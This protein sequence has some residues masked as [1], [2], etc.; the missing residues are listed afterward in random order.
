M[1]AFGLMSLFAAGRTRREREIA[2]LN[3]SVSHTDVERRQLEIAR[4]KFRNY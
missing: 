2:Y 4:G 1:K 3:E